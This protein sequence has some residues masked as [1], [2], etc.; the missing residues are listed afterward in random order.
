MP[1]PQ[2]R[3]DWLEREVVSQLFE[4]FGNPAQIERAVRRAVPDC[5]QLLKRQAALAA[6][7]AKLLKARERVLAMIIKDVLT[8]KQTE[9]Q[10]SELKDREGMLRKELD[11]LS[12]QLADLPDEETLRCYVQRIDEAIFVFDHNGQTYAG[13]N[14]VMSYVLMS[15]ADKKHLIDAVFAKP[16]AGGEPAGVYVTPSAAP[17][18]GKNKRTRQWHIT[19]KGQLEF[20]SVVPS[21]RHKP[22]GRDRGATPDTS[23]HPETH[24]STNK[25]TLGT[26]KLASRS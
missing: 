18:L 3:A 10:L 19:L 15:H 1:L 17:R 24:P 23:V 12:V 13:G 11:K 4:L 20:E 8:D 2:V 7:L 6:D 16:L 14:D 9:S 22:Q 26:L 21:C 25:N 5:D